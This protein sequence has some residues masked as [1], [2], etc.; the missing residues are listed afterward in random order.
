MFL[1][2]TRPAVVQNMGKGLWIY[3]VMILRLSSERVILLSQKKISPLDGQS[4]LVEFCLALSFLG[5]CID[6]FRRAYDASRMT[7]YRRG[8]PAPGEFRRWGSFSTLR[9]KCGKRF[10]RFYEFMDLRLMLLS[11]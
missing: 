6:T 7:M 2:K 11:D 8:K 4:G 1:R 3:D 5:V 10:L 9:W